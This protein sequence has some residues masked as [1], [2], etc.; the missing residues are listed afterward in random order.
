MAKAWIVTHPETR[1]DHEGRIHGHL[2]PPLSYTGKIKAIQIAKSFQ[3]KGVIRVHSSPRLR[4]RELA[5]MIGKVTGARVEVHE[6]LAP[7]DLANM[8]GAKTA[9]IK[10][11]LDFFGS[12]PDRPVPGGESK[13]DVLNRYTKF[14][15][16]IQPGDVIVGHSQ[17]SLAW[18]FAKKG[19]DAKKV[20]MIGGHAGKVREV[21]V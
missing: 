14:A 2:D 21:N 17:H 12:R 8:S 5:Q 1:M 10:P 11:L 19:G 3:G 13:G 15:K 9:S 18:D 7:W 6:E 20:P 4:A 16:T